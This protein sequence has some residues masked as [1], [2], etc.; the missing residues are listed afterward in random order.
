MN[1]EPPTRAY[2]RENDPISALNVSSAVSANLA[3]KK[4]VKSVPLLVLSQDEARKQ[5]KAVLDSLYPQA[6]KKC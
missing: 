5:V 2:V 4:G 3:R 6:G 1:D